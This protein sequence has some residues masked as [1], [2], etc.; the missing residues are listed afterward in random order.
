[1]SAVRNWMGD[2]PDEQP[3]QLTPPSFGRACLHSMHLDPKIFGVHLGFF[4]AC[5]VHTNEKT[6]GVRNLFSSWREK[7]YDA[8]A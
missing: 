2:L 3:K 1:M 4:S 6:F 5:G 8:Q 7:L